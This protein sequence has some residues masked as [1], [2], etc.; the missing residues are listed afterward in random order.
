MQVP[1]PAKR[2]LFRS[3]SGS[4]SNVEHW[5]STEQPSTCSSPCRCRGRVTLGLSPCEIR[6]LPPCLTF[7]CSFIRSDGNVRFSSLPNP[8]S[9][10]VKGAGVTRAETES[11]VYPGVSTAWESSSAAWKSFLGVLPKLSLTLGRNSSIPLQL[12]HPD[13]AGRISPGAA[14]A[15]LRNFLDLN[16]PP[17]SCLRSRRQ[18][19]LIIFPLPLYTQNWARLWWTPGENSELAIKNKEQEKMT[20]WAHPGRKPQSDASFSSSALNHWWIC[21]PQSGNGWILG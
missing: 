19:N 3:W 14:V 11:C 9:S 5:A 10:L 12:L 21:P 7:S 1:L 18:S 13:L 2:Y 4:S 8:S 15:P 17:Q 16:R 6:L 20:K